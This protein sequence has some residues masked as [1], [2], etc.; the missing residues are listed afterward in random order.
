MK[1]KL[2]FHLCQPICS[3]YSDASKNLFSAADFSQEIINSQFNRS[4]YLFY[5]SPFTKKTN[6]L[7]QTQKWAER[8]TP[9]VNKTLG[10]VVIALFAY[11]FKCEVKPPAQD[12]AE[13]QEMVDGCLAEALWYLHIHGMVTER[14]F[15]ARTPQLFV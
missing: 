9:T 8:N 12:Q 13:Q 1:K 2:T 10:Q 14:A 6:G 7:K 3:D 5:A 11:F 4:L 15:S